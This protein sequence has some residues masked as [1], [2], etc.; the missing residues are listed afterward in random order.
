MDGYEILIWVDIIFL[1]RES[2]E[3]ENMSTA[4][5]NWF[6][7]W[8]VSYAALLWTTV[9]ILKYFTE[10]HNWPITINCVRKIHQCWVSVS[11]LSLLRIVLCGFETEPYEVYF[12]QVGLRFIR[13][14]VFLRSDSVSAETTAAGAQHH[15]WWCASNQRL[16]LWWWAVLDLTPLK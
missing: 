9:I 11:A 6:S 10:Y 1:H 3:K 15:L 13:G 2:V 12:N 4:T 5:G 16:P 14:C 7:S 8:K